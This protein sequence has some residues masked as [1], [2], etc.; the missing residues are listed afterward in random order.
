MTR[1][2]LPTHGGSFVRDPKDG[3]LRDGSENPEAA[4]TP[5]P[6]ADEAPATTPDTKRKGGK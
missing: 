6:E 4:P 5:E 3:A 1:R 2:P